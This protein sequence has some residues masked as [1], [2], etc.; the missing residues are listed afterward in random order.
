MTSNE[1]NLEVLRLAIDIARDNAY[2]RRGA[3]MEQWE[4]RTDEQPAPGP[5][6]I[7]IEEV[8]QLYHEFQD[9]V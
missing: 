2:A 8:K 3:A 4:R 5:A 7:D 1:V 9:L 6:V